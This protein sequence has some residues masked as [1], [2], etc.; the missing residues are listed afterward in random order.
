M[1]LEMRG[2]DESTTRVHEIRDLAQ[3]GEHLLDEC[4]SPAPEVAVKSLLDVR[5]MT[6]GHQ[7]A[8]HMRPAD[9]GAGGFALDILPRHREAQGVHAIHH[10]ARTPGAIVP[11][12]EE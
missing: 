4:W 11:R 2:R 1:I 5:G 12:P 6:A 8:R 3:R 7:R 9:R 10:L